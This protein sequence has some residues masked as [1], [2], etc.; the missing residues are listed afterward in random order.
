MRSVRPFLLAAVA[1]PRGHGCGVSLML[2]FFAVVAA[3]NLCI[4]YVLGA[5]IGIL[6]GIV[7]REP[8]QDSFEQDDLLLSA[9]PHVVAPSQPIEKREPE[10]VVASPEPPSADATE[11]LLAELASFRAKLAKVHNGLQKVDGDRESLGQCADELRQANNAYAEGANHAV[12]RFEGESEAT[13]RR[14]ELAS[15]IQQQTEALEQA[16]VAIGELLTSDDAATVQQGLITTTNQLDKQAVLVE[17]RAVASQLPEADEVTPPTSVSRAVDRE[18]LL[19]EAARQLAS[20]DQGMRLQMA[21]VSFDTQRADG[22]AV[23]VNPRLVDG[24]L[25]V[26]E[27]L[28]DEGQLTAV[29]EGRLLMLL[30]GDDETTA[31]QRC[32]RLRQQVAATTFV[33]EGETYQLTASCSVA[34]SASGLPVQQIVTNV[35][36][37]LVEARRY[38]PNRCFHHDGKFPAPVVPHTMGVEE[39]TLEV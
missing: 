1:K 21:G 31:I 14:T 28:L 15:S 19:G 37:S 26:V 7:R 8:E 27:E 36:E 24:L 39:L 9:P 16:N 12:S 4:G 2:M 3:A 23:E 13:P 5:T 22:T 18:H 29:D 30:T 25:Q 20:I 34:D 32:E 33:C 6:P 35:E 17:N 11:E 10:P 38:G